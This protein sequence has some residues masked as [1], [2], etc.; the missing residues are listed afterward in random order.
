MTLPIVELFRHHAWANLELLAFCADAPPEA[1][2][3]AEPGTYGS[4]R[5]T[6]VHLVG[7]EQRYLAALGE[8]EP[9]VRVAEGEGFPGWDALRTSAAWSGE[10]LAE[11]AGVEPGGR[12][13]RGVRRGEPFALPATL[14]LVQAVDHGKEHR[15]HVATILGRHGIEPPELDGWSFEPQ[16]ERAEG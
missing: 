16:L 10:R 1:L 14:F 11:L 15:T 8:T 5:D 7:A 2:D 13:V 3:T 9:P 4:I 6:L 12:I